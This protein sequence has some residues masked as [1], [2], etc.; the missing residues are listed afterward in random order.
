LARNATTD[1]HDLVRC[2]TLMIGS[3]LAPDAGLLLAA[4]SAAMTLLD[5]RLA[6]TLA[7][8]AVAAGGGP[9]ARI[10]HAMA[11]TLQERGTEAEA[12]LAE[13]ADQM[14]GAARAQIAIIRAINFAV[15][16]GQLTSAE[17]ELI[18]ALPADDEAAGAIANSFTTFIDLVRGHTVAAVDRASVLLGDPP[19]DAFAHMLLIWTLVSGLGDLGRIDEIES[20]ASRG[21]RLAEQCADVSHLR[22]ALAFF[23]ANAYRLA[24]ALTESDATTARI[25]RDTLDVPYEESFHLFLAG[26]SAMGRG[27]LAEGQ[28]LYQESLAF[29][30]T[31]GG[32]RMIKSFA[33]CW[34][35]TVSGMAGRSADARRDFTAIQLSS[36]DPD[37]HVWEDSEK[38][39]AQAWVCA[40]EN[41]VSQA[42]LMARDA[43]AAESRL[44]RIAREVC[45]LQAATQFGDHTTAE[46][47]AELAAR[48]QG[49]RAQA[50]AA[51][52]AAL[53]AG[54]GD[55]LVEVSRMYEAFGD[56]VAAADAAAQA[57][58]AYQL[59]GRRGA[60]LTASATARRLADECGGARTPAL[61]A[62]TVPVAITARQR[63]IISLAAKGMSNK[64]IAQQLSMSV[65][66]VQGHVFRASQ[67]VGVNSRDELI[68]LL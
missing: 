26:M 6:E 22:F 60:A 62:A 52:A 32:G 66:S 38:L 25:R 18:E 68:A 11:I 3:D 7:E 46:R 57:V 58:G 41:A 55:A 21:Y 23:H 53:A 4:A 47:L 19:A 59:V 49:P 28:R 64:E 17:S 34:L 31:T 33:G 8:R 13:L 48:V 50:A 56:R 63:E 2:A 15:N 24:G 35:A 16:L 36:H 40:A 12:I 67:R 37:A 9:A 61:R 20:A 1:P 27:S 5:V 14:S 30:A 39:L 10:L 45:A 43:A 29:V 42:I 44:D 54:S 51:H 65:R